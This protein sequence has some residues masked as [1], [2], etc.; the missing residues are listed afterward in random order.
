MINQLV[1]NITGERRTVRISISTAEPNISS[2]LAGY[3]EKE[4]AHK[5][6][7]SITDH[8]TVGQLLS[9]AEASPIDL[10]ILML[11]NLRFTDT[12]LF[13]N[14]PHWQPFEVVSYLK[15][16]YGKPVIAL[17]GSWPESVKNIEEES[18]QAGASVFFFVPV[19]TNH[20]IEAVENCMKQTLK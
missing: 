3:M 8:V 18:K 5:F 17:A 15:V 2:M 4:L 7:L 13:R 16:Q 9:H 14:T 20:F 6:D 1:Q 11:N 19:D 12:P 10:F